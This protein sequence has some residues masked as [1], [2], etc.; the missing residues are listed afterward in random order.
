M[1][2][3]N[4]SQSKYKVTHK[5]FPAIIKIS[6][7]N[8]KNRSF[9][10]YSLWNAET[11]EFNSSKILIHNQIRKSEKMVYQNLASLHK[12]NTLPL[13]TNFFLITSS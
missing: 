11:L 9:N 1:C 4:I 5:I 12:R 6:R 8:C 10:E 2:Y 7:N 13:T 3:W